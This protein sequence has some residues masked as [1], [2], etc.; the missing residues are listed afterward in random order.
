MFVNIHQGLLKYSV[1]DSSSYSFTFSDEDVP[2]V[3]VAAVWF[4]GVAY[5]PTL[6]PLNVRF[7][8]KEKEALIKVTPDKTEY[9]PGENV[10]LN[11]VVKDVAGK[12]LESTL[13][14]NLVD[15]AFYQLSDEQANPLS[16]LYKIIYSD[17]YVYT[18]HQYVEPVGESGAEGGGD[19]D[20]GRQSFSDVALF[21]T[22][23]TNRQGEATVTFK[24]PDNITSWRITAQSISADLHA[25]VEIT[26]IPVS[27]PL[28]ADVTLAPEYL[29]ADQPIVKARA[30]GTNLKTGS[31]VT[32]GFEIPS[33]G[34]AKQT[35]N[36]SA[37]AA[38]YFSLPALKE[39]AHTATLS[40]V[41][42][43]NNDTLSKK[44]QVITSR[45]QERTHDYTTLKENTKITGSNQ[46]RTTLVFTDAGRG[47][48]Y[49]DLVGL[50]WNYSDR[51]DTKL[52]GLLS[53]Q[54]LEKDFNQTYYG[55][56]EVEWLNYQADNGGIT[57]VPYSSADLELSAKVALS[58]TEVFDTTGL[59]NYFYSFLFKKDTNKDELALSYLGLASLHEPVLNSLQRFAKIGDLT[60]KDQLYTA[61]ALQTIGDNELARDMYLKIMDKYGEQIKPFIR[62]NASKNNDENTELT[63]LSALL[64]SSL[65]AP[66]QDGLWQYA[67]QNYSKESP[68]SLEKLLTIQKHREFT[69]NEEASFTAEVEGKKTDYKLEPGRV[70]TLS[71][72]PD[73]LRTL[74]L[75][76]GKGSV[77]VVS[78]YDKPTTPATS[79][80]APVSIKR[81]YLVKGKVTSELNQGDLAEVRLYPTISPQAINGSY[82]ITDFIPSGLKMITTPGRNDIQGVS[83]NVYR[84]AC[85]IY[86]PYE[87]NGQTVKFSYTKGNSLM[88]GNGYISYYVRVVSPGTYQAE[89]ASIQSFQS[90]AVK[91]Y[92]APDKITIKK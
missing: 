68:L 90:D 63:L 62:I 77:S 52:A 40:A 48:M 2:N 6:D 91:N 56:D 92:S 26:K 88:C 74:T 32:F 35:V 89:P 16:D 83:E 11:V 80:A 42:G 19:G 59:K 65:N 18:T 69:T 46:S 41:A 71:L 66:E 45:I 54:L 10:T 12:P 25:G 23:K 82:Q 81:E 1:Q 22:T 29:I 44:F 50:T 9:K 85:L 7:N 8:P 53:R 73:Q 3:T 49:N 36:G 13:N 60:V 39:G 27:L 70:V 24:L 58:K 28:F 55:D 86:H 17:F 43:S 14:L 84:L 37:F 75:K 79:A 30:Y 34:L 61:L 47:S 76:P 67:Q 15:E 87:I 51:V 5:R 38:Q 33:L 4:D 78:L 20:G 72:A 31:P 64:S 57:L 21:T